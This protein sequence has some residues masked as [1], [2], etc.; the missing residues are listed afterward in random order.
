MFARRGRRRSGLS[1][2]FLVGVLVTIAVLM[3]FAR[4]RSTS[5]AHDRAIT[6]LAGQ[7][8]AG[9]AMLALD[10]AYGELSTALAEPRHPVSRVVTRGLLGSSKPGERL[11]LQEFFDGTKVEP[12]LSWKRPRN[13]G[14]GPMGR[15]TTRVEAAI[16]SI[17]PFAG[18]AAEEAALSHYEKSA[19][20]RLIA[21]T[22]TE[23][24]GRTVERVL[25]QAFELRMQLTSPPVPFSDTGFYLHEMSAVTDITAL[26]QARAKLVALMGELDALVR[27]ATAGAPLD[28]KGNLAQILRGLPGDV[29][30]K[31]PRFAGE[32]VALVA[33]TSM[34]TPFA[35]L[36]LARRLGPEMRRLQAAVQRVEK[37]RRG[38]GDEAALEE[39]LVAALRVYNRA[40]GQL[41]TFGK[42][43]ATVPHES[44]EF[45]KHLAP[46]LARLDPAWYGERVM[47]TLSAGDEP[48]TAW[49]AGKV[50]LN[51]VFRVKGDEPLVIQGPVR[52]RVFLL[53]E[54]GE[55]LLSEIA[56]R[57]DPTERLTVLASRGRLRVRGEVHASVVAA[58]EAAVEIAPG[59]V[60]IGCLIQGP[61]DRPPR[62]E[63]SLQAVPLPRAQLEKAA[64][65]GAHAL[66]LS[67]SPL[68]TV[69][70]RE[71]ER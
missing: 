15:T 16:D 42:R 43:I 28:P 12:H 7:N 30:A 4:S 19:V 56:A 23:L 38:G 14:I 50:A 52:G 8:A 58:G 65:E 45:A 63:G 70:T 10:A 29:D 36:D 61:S 11:D 41:W 1:S 53:V 64:E 9:T 35:E 17:R 31:L 49:L 20:L 33:R 21:T 26:E 27:E 62:L 51:G 32:N 44:D 55:V 37:V 57:S 60:L 69:G 34:S 48:M 18:G 54:S 39:S 59:S 25:E 68:W 46:Y 22:R 3:L 13:P 66:A 71:T 40:S 67:P 5:Q 6:L 47:A 24:G 2:F